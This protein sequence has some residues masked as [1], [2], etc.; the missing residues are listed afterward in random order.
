[1]NRVA[2]WE[3]EVAA[4]TSIGDAVDR[5]LVAYETHHTGTAA[6]QCPVP[7]LIAWGRSKLDDG[8]QP[9]IAAA[10]LLLALYLATHP[11]AQSNRTRAF[12][13]IGWAREQAAQKRAA[14]P[15]PGTPPK[16]VVE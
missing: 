16:R 7:W 10:E 3:Q 6:S 5:L 12:A 9:D 13:L 8:H 14:P 4:W 1:V 2:A 15:D 11:D